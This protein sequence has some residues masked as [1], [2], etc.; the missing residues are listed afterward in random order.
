MNQSV[1]KTE[2]S[3]RINIENIIKQTIDLL[4]AEEARK[5]RDVEIRENNDILKRENQKKQS[6]FIH[7]SEKLEQT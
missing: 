6:E 3:E 1:E 2:I 5:K 7:K 4:E